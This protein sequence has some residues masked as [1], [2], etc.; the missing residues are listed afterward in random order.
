MHTG[1][2]SNK[3]NLIYGEETIQV[4]D[5]KLLMLHW[6]FENECE[7]PQKSVITKWLPQCPK[8]RDFFLLNCLGKKLLGVCQD[9]AA[10]KFGEVV[11]TFKDAHSVTQMSRHV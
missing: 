8:V 6:C 5:V 4:A 9:I 3:V 7:T 10:K 2:R 1:E 11:P